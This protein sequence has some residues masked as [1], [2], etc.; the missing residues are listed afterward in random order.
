MASACVAQRI[1]PGAV[2]VAIDEPHPAVREFLRLH[3]GLLDLVPHGDVDWYSVTKLVVVDT[4]SPDRLGA[5]RF[6]LH[7][8]DIEVHIFDHHV[9]D[10]ESVQADFSCQEPMGAAVTV[11]LKH[12]AERL[13]GLPSL[14]AEEATLCLVAIYEETGCFR[15]PS[16][17][18]QDLK[19]AGLLLEMGGN[20]SVVSRYYSQPLSPAQLAVLD[21]MI[22][23]G[24]R[25][26]LDG[27][28]AWVAVHRAERHFGS[29]SEI[30]SR[31]QELLGVDVVL[32]GLVHGENSVHWVARS[33]DPVFDVSR[34]MS[35][36]GGG[37]HACAA[38]A[39][40]SL[41]GPDPLGQARCRGI[42]LTRQ[43]LEWSADQRPACASQIMSTSCERIDWDGGA[44]LTVLTTYLHL[45]DRGQRAA[46]VFKQSSPWG[47]ITVGDLSKALH[48]GLGDSH[49]KRFCTHP[50]PSVGP[51]ATLEQVQQTM[52]E[53]DLEWVA[54][55]G[56]DSKLQGWVSRAG[57]LEHLYRQ[58]QNR[59]QATFVDSG[60][61]DRLGQPI[62]RYLKE[63][64]QLAEARQ[65]RLFLVGGVVRDLLLERTTFEDFDCVVEGDGLSLSKEFAARH[66]LQLRQHEKFGTSTLHWTDGSLSLDIATARRETYC[67]PAALPAVEDSHMKEDLF[68]RDFSINAMAIAL[69]P[70][71]WGV[72]VDPFGGRRDLADGRVRVLHNH[73]F[74][75]DPTRILR[76]VRFEQRL[77]FQLGDATL[78]QLE[79]AVGEGILQRLTPGRLKGE[80]WAS[81]REPRALEI[82]WR[83]GEVGVFP[84]V[85]PRLVKSAA[86]RRD[87]WFSL[88]ERFQQ[89]TAVAGVALKIDFAA[90]LWQ[91][92]LEAQEEPWR[93]KFADHSLLGPQ[94]V[95]LLYRLSGTRYGPSE[96]YHAL[97][98]LQEGQL[99]WLWALA[100]FQKSGVERARQSILDFL[101]HQRAVH[102]LLTGADL[103]AAGL[104]PGPIYK[105][106]LEQAFDEQLNSGWETRQQAMDWL[107]HDTRNA[108]FFA[109]HL[110]RQK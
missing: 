58:V 56:P 25:V 54:V 17:N 81:C 9:P 52:V 110:T 60:L 38:A 64:G 6:L 36:I 73:S 100:P 72:L 23:Q 109:E 108:S 27:H 41:V 15:F 80:L 84:W 51:E 50:L 2:C 107:C 48:H 101:C 69:N 10:R 62:F 43:L 75:D 18:A 19:M 68:R 57:L 66:A 24:E 89:L 95:S 34:L 32:I 49:I 92:W 98:S 76:G 105:Q 26:V 83:L 65:E 79:Q 70:K 86:E 5:L 40:Q 42:E 7:R 29:L 46:V 11:V 45:R 21:E 91:C 37:G 12:L 22:R 106:I 85:W 13:G 96:R 28:V 93:E 97:R 78:H 77:G 61:L 82:L 71:V 16:T 102:P 1:Y 4:C 47:L 90:A 39:R 74:F 30:V 63:L 103:K 3:P 67:R 8:R 53:Q 44:N 87:F 59:G 31:I 20:L 14:S 55:V 33:S 99:L 104:T 88:Q 35:S 94:A